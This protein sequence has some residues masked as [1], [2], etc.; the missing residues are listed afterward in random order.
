MESHGQYWASHADSAKADSPWMGVT[1][2]G[3]VVPGLDGTLTAMV[4]GQGSPAQPPRGSVCTPI[5]LQQRRPV[6]RRA[7]GEGAGVGL[8]KGVSR[9]DTGGEICAD[10]PGPQPTQHTPSNRVQVTPAKASVQV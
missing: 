4:R 5:T 9:A 3:P 10:L 2:K 8:A 7:G 6:Q 1:A